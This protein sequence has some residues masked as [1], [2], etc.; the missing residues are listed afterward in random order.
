MQPSALFFAAIAIASAPAA[1]QAPAVVD[2][3]KFAYEPREITVAPGTTV[4]WTN[5]DETPHTVTDK[6][7]ELGKRLGTREL[8]VV[9]GKHE[10]ALIDTPLERA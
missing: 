3:T 7:G 2:I 1:A 8:V 4:N 5:R 9:R 10:L 6:A